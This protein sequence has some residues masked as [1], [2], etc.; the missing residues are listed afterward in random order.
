M[1]HC[2]WGACLA[3]PSLILIGMQS[4][5]SDVDGIAT[6]I[7]DIQYSIN[8]CESQLRSLAV[9]SHIFTIIQSHENTPSTPQ[10]PIF[11]RTEMPQ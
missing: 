10:S 7:A 11:K 9:H 8:E 1:D 3:R 6:L 5:A 2:E 4:R